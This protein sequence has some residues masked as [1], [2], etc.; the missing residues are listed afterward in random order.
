MRMIHANLARNRASCCAHVV[1]SQATVLEALGDG[2][3]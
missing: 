1:P 3:R 2:V